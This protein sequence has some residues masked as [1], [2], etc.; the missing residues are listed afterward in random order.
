MMALLTGIYVAE[1]IL[2]A[3]LFVRL[4]KTHD[5]RYRYLR[6]LLV[7]SLVQ[8]LLFMLTLTDTTRIPR[9]YFFDFLLSEACALISVATDLIVLMTMQMLL[10]R[11]KMENGLSR[12]LFY[13]FVL[14]LLVD[15]LI[16]LTNP[17]HGF[18]FSMQQY[19]VGNFSVILFPQGQTW[20][21]IRCYVL[22]LQT[23]TVAVALFYRGMT[24]PLLYGVK[25]L[26]FC[27]FVTLAFVLAVCYS[28]LS[29]TFRLRYMLMVNISLLPFFLYF[30]VYYNRPLLSS[31]YV[32]QMVVEKLGSPVVLFDADNLLVDYNRDAAE[33]F[34]LERD[35]VNHLTLRDF[36]LRSVGNQMRERTSSTVEEVTVQDVRGVQQVF[37]LDYS[38]L[39]DSKKK[40]LGT[41]LLFHNITELKQLYSTMEKTAMTDMLTGLASKNMLEKK[42]SEIN[43]YRK[44]P[45]CAAEIGR[46]HV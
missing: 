4:V 9:L 23:L 28:Y 10:R 44:Y 18:A 36:L 46:A 7:V 43:L 37:K 14:F 32:R 11:L 16:L 6:I 15:A 34:A 3:L 33:L 27:F 40:S 5:I 8:L 24:L 30:F 2:L 19:P 1:I 41:L 20:M 31:A 35:L 45:Y 12:A 25:Y 13:P 39:S 42:I 26:V 22:L 29:E 17:L 21:G 38:K